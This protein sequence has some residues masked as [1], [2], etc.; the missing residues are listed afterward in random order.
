MK[1]FALLLISLFIFI[2]LMFG[3]SAYA[4]GVPQEVL[5]A[6][7]S[8]VYIEVEYSLGIGSGSGFVVK[9]DSSGTYI[10]TNDHVVEVNPAGIS[11]WI[12]KG[13]KRSATVVEHSKELD[14]AILKLTKP[15]KADALTLSGDAKQGDE[16]FA[17]GFPA[18]ADYLSNTEAH[19]GSEATITNGI[20]SSVR[21]MKIID[22]G[23]E[24]K[25][26]QINAD[27]NSGNSG[28]PLLNARGKVV[29]I[30]SYGA[31]DSQGIFGA[32]SAD[33]LIS[34]INDNNIF[35]I[36]AD[37]ASSAG[38]LVY[39]LIGLLAAAI[40]I[41]IFVPKLRNTIMR[42]FKSSNKR[43]AGLNEYLSKF[44]R[45][46]DA[47]SIVGLIMP[48]IL[49]LRDRHTQGSVYLKLSLS[50]VAVTKNG[51][52]LKEPEN[53]AS[54]EFS[55]PESREGKFAGIRAD[56]FGV[57]ALIRYVL[58]YNYPFAADVTPRPGSALAE[59]QRIINK[60]LEDRPEDRY[61]NMQDLISELSPF[62]RGI[63]EG[64]LLPLSETRSIPAKE[65]RISA[66][67]P[68]K[69]PALIAIL[70]GCGLVLVFFIFSAINYLSAVSCAGNY[71]F[72]EA[73]TYIRNVAFSKDIF[74]ADYS[75]IDAGYDMANRD[76]DS[77]IR[78]LESN[79]NRGSKSDEL[80]K[81]A[82]YRKA[83]MLA[84]QNDFDG[85]VA[86]YSEISGY[87][88]SAQLVNDTKLRKAGYYISNAKFLDALSI[89]M[90]LKNYGHSDADEK[91]CELYYVWGVSLLSKEDYY[92]A[93]LKLSESKGYR[94][95]NEL[96][97]GLQAVLY[98]K[99][100]EF[101]HDSKYEVATAYFKIIGSYLRTDDYLRLIYVQRKIDITDDDIWGF[102]VPLIGF[103][104]AADLLVETPDKAKI[105]LLGKWGSGSRY[106]KF[107]KKNDDTW[108]EFN[109][110]GWNGDWY[111]Y[112]GLYFIEL[113]NGSFKEVFKITVVS[114]NCI[115]L[116]A[117]RNGKTYTLY[118][119]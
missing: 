36:D 118:R 38:W 91:I 112:D 96:L 57:C 84:D 54:Y 97:S 24:V 39:C 42:I 44:D 61:A 9:N 22:Y 12:G 37:E 74:P 3:L 107:Y 6:G 71:D 83:A 81:E 79:K 31:L 4:S 35:H 103:E 70:T 29:G 72:K 85:S 43:E 78:K 80:I 25:L 32:I 101:Y 17:V 30:N 111:I 98:N 104:D 41:F 28:G 27:L 23:P 11:V 113:K 117:Y 34:F 49:E 76:Y 68:K 116:Y 33:E 18:A 50:G 94:D 52:K 100:I 89:L 92:N 13:D 77:A 66:I 99:A 55:A 5:N 14:L 1:R 75:Y 73:Y 93:Y 40:L 105:F 20:V 47:C 108:C 64:V 87:K 90:E 53:N 69:K 58:N 48:V 56:I 114:E 15:I 62:N 16:V 60:G 51:F 10:A 21:T 110:S 109:I 65:K 67:K 59:L 102:L 95:T 63:P 82:K 2:S 7:A 46:L 86:L 88:N 8:V 19:L 115:K 119:Q 45:P 106:I 26:L